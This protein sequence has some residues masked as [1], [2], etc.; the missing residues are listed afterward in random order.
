VLKAT[1]D[2]FSTPFVPTVMHGR[3]FFGSFQFGA[4]HKIWIRAKKIMKPRISRHCV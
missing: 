3:F 2:V 4:I 1:F